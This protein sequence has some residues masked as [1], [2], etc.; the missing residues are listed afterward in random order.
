MTTLNVEHNLNDDELFKAIIS[1]SKSAGLEERV[2]ESLAKALPACDCPKEPKDPVV[3]QLKKQMHGFWLQARQGIFE[4]VDKIFAGE[5]SW[6]DMFKGKPAT[7]YPDG[8]LSPEQIKALQQAIQDRFDYIASEIDGDRIPDRLTLRRWKKQGIIADNVSASDF[9]ATIPGSSR[10]I[11]NAFVFGRLHLAIEKGGSYDDILKV[12][13][14]APLTAPDQYAVKVAEQQAASYI[15]SFGESLSQDVVSLALSRNRKIIHD[16]AV[17]FHKNELPI[18]KLNGFADDK[19]ASTWQEFK[20]ELYH[21]LDDRARDWDRIAFYEVYDAKRYGEAL[22]LLADFGPGQLVYKSPLTTACAQCKQL[23]LNG[24]IP[25]LYRLSDMIS[26]GNNIGRK[27]MPT[28]GGVVVSEERP[29]GAE[30]LKAVAGLV[31]PY[32]ECQGPMIFTGMEWW[33]D[34]AVRPA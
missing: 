28:R 11:R 23:Y 16:M 14:S 17:K 10:V 13:I 27:P 8:P 21:A 30:T 25:R 15:S 19:Y 26:Y 12:A 24:N 33:A 18:T 32:C 3:L 34:E 4:S 22:R 5:R 2:S 31:H 9:A 20:S 6:L 1:L 29:D 7:L